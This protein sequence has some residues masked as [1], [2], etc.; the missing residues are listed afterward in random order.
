MNYQQQYSRTNG[1]EYFILFQEVIVPL[2]E[3]GS[4]LT[5]DMEKLGK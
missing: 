1:I 2:R 3:K 5:R 4:I